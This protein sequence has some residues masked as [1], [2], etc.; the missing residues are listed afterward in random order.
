[1]CEALRDRGAVLEEPAHR[2]RGSRPD[3]VEDSD[4]VVLSEPQAPIREITHID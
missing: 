2:H 1:M 4:A 3:G